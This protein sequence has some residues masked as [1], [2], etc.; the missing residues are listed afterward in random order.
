MNEWEKKFC[1][2]HGAISRLIKQGHSPEEAVKIASTMGKG[3]TE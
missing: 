2:F 1:V 3:R